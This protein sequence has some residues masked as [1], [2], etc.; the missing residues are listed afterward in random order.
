MHGSAPDIASKGIAN[1]VGQI[2]SA[3]KMLGHLGDRQSAAA[4]Q[5][6]FE[7]APERGGRHILTPDM[8]GE[9]S[10]EFLGQAVA[11]EIKSAV[12]TGTGY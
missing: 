1:P 10:I 11:E 3:A 6:G 4:V 8:G 12:L 5:Q 7:N 2:W 9:A